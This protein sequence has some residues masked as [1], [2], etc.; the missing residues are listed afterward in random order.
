M[1]MAYERFRDKQYRV[2]YEM[3]LEKFVTGH[4]PIW[5]L[6]FIIENYKQLRK[7]SFNYYKRI[8]AQK[9]IENKILI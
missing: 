7:P 5:Q 6:L 9:Q 2:A 3:M 4:A 1:V 8:E